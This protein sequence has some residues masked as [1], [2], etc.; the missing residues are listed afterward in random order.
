[1]TVGVSDFFFAEI[2]SGLASGDVVELEQPKDDHGK[3]A[4]VAGMNVGEAAAGS[5][6]PAAAPAAKPRGATSA[7]MVTRGT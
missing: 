5:K 4:K 6:S 3:I 7:P 2:Q 1:M